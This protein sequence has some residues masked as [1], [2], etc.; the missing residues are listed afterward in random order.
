M[1]ANEPQLFFGMPIA[2]TVAII[3]GLVTIL[4]SSI[5]ILLTQKYASK[6]LQLT[7][8]DNQCT[9]EENRQ[10]LKLNLEASNQ[11]HRDELAEKRTD[12]V[13]EA[14]LK[15]GSELLE[16]LTRLLVNAQVPKVDQELLTNNL[17]E[18]KSLSAHASFLYH[19]SW[20]D[21]AI[22]S[23]EKLCEIVPQLNRAR[24]RLE[25]INDWYEETME[26][27]SATWLF[28]YEQDLTDKGLDVEQ[29]K[30]LAEADFKQQSKHL[31]AGAFS[32]NTN[33]FLLRYDMHNDLNNVTKD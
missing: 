24:K 9:R 4:V 28:M 29:E 3:S 33:I 13:F 14:K 22:Q 23:A 27:S 11:K 19:A 30:E 15:T 2:V 7:L 25:T 21:S 31:E 16:A 20:S 1:T 32:L 8:E 12:R 18:I 10:Q 6:N 26:G 5:T 17:H